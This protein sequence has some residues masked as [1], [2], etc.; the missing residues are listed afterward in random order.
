[1]VVLSFDQVDH[2]GTVAEV[3]VLEMAGLFEDV[4]SA[5]DRRRIDWRAGQLLNALMQIGSAEMIVVR[6]GQNLAHRPPGTG[7]AQAGCSQ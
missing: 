6:L 3:D 7:D 5:V 1:M 2:A 4:D